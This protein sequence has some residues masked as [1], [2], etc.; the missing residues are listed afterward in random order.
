M[1]AMVFAA[2][3]E[4][5]VN[6]VQM[7]RI[8]PCFLRHRGIKLYGKLEYFNP[9]GSVKDRLAKAIICDA[10]AS[11]ALQPGMAVIEATSGNT[12]YV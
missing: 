3:A 6:V 5:V 9:L 4:R 8:L 12:G 7:S 11:G 10:E 1:Y 2:C